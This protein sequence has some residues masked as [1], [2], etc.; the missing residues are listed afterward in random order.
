MERKTMLSEEKMAVWIV[1]MI[2]VT[3]ILVVSVC[4]ITNAINKKNFVDHGYIQHRDPGSDS[5]IWVKPT[6][7]ESNE[8]EMDTTQTD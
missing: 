5:V 6:R 2:L 7:D 3:I 8:T 4:C 1:G